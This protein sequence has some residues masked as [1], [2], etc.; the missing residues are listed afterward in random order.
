MELLGALESCDVFDIQINWKGDEDGCE[1]HSE[2][3]CDANIFYKEEEEDAH[4]IELRWGD[5]EHDVHS[6][7][8]SAKAL[9]EARVKHGFCIV[10]G[11]TEVDM[12]ELAETMRFRLYS[13]R[14]FK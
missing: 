4:Q 10:E 2:F 7:Y 11:Y 13:T 5:S 12:P 8:L 3:L 1:R 9:N 6:V 14:P